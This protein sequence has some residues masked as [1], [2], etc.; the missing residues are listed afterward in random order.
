MKKLYTLIILLIGLILVGCTVRP[1]DT[2]LES[3]QVNKENIT[4]FIGESTAIEYEFVPN[5]ISEEVTWNI[6]NDDIVEVN[7]NIV[8][9]LNY[10][11]TSISIISSSNEEIKTT[12]KISVI[13]RIY[14]IIYELNG[15]YFTNDVVNTFEENIGLDT[16]ATP[17]K[18]G[19]IFLGWYLGENKVTNISPDI[20]EDITLRSVVFPLPLSPSNVTRPVSG[21]S[22]VVSLITW[23][24]LYFLR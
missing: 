1:S 23:I 19:Y 7:D 8:T 6:E 13:R 21:N 11:E 9:A 15:S 3:I 14:N 10:G 20:N 2:K 5:S 17:I 4:L 24:S 18:D 22:N 16:L 12:I